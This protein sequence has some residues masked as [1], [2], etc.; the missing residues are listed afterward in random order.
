MSLTHFTGLDA[1]TST[2]AHANDMA[3]TQGGVA[4]CARSA[5]NK[6]GLL[7]LD[8]VS[9]AGVVT[10][11]YLWIDSTGDLRVGRAI[12]TDQDGEGTVVGTQS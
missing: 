8:A 11:Y 5:A 10:P 12:P 4:C 1:D 9:D 7:R 6:P 3:A 2:S